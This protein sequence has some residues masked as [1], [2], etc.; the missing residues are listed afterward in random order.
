MSHPSSKQILFKAYT[1]HDFVRFMLA[2][3]KKD[4]L[5]KQFLKYYWAFTHDSIFN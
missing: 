1:S 4:V 5:W 2:E 3:K